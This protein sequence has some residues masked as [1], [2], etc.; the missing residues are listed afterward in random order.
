MPYSINKTNGDLLLTLE[1]GTADLT[2]TSLTLVGRNYPGYGEY[3]NENFVK[4]LEN[5]A[6]NTQPPSAITGQIWYDAASKILKVY[7][8]VNFVSTGGGVSLDTTSVSLHYLTFVDNDT[9]LPATKVAKEKGIS[10]Q[11][12][13]GNMSINKFAPATSK[14]EINN[15]PAEKTLNA[16]VENT[17]LHLHGNNNTNARLLIDSYGGVA[18]ATATLNFR[19]SPIPGSLA[20][21]SLGSF[22]GNIGAMGWNGDAFT[23]RARICF[24]GAQTWTTAANGTKIEFYTTQNFSTTTVLSAVM[25]D[26]GDFEAKGDIIGFSLSDERLKT[27]VEKIENALDKIDQL[28]GVVYNWNELAETLGKNTQVQETGLLAGAVAEVLP[29]ATHRRDNGMLAVNYEKLMGLIV[30]GIKELRAEVDSL[31]SAKAV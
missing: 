26:N 20:P 3:F 10:F 5:F 14:L 31:K 13:S 12:S 4:L 22:M 21:Q 11:P 2:S 16:P 23:E 1:D 25:H 28:Q 19:R 29:Q 30:E 17:I 18:T 24:V 27:N 8:G 6:R 7:D 9:G 15:G